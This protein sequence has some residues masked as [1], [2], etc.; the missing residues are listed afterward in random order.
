M[1]T[2]ILIKEYNTLM[3]YKGG[4]ARSQPGRS[5]TSRA[6]F[7]TL[8]KGDLMETNP[9]HYDN[10]VRTVPRVPQQNQYTDGRYVTAPPSQQRSAVLQNQRPQQRGGA[11]SPKSAER[12]PKARALALARTLKKWL[13]IASLAGFGTFSGLVAYH[14]VGTT[15]TSTKSGSSQKTVSATPSSSQNSNSNSFFKQQGGNN[16]GSNNSSS[17]SASGSDS[18]SSTSLSGS[19]GSSNSSSTPVSGSG[20][21]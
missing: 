20:V 3:A 14:Q 2:H 13:V 16:F 12:M 11:Y 5:A 19:G 6:D 8:H 17:T 1:K 9:Y 21:S 4:G 15:A 10:Y 18:S 7:H